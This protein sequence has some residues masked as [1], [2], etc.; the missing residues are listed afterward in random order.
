MSNTQR[1]IASPTRTRQA[2]RLLPVLSELRQE[3]RSLSRHAHRLALAQAGGDDACRNQLAQLFER[4]IED[5]SPRAQVICFASAAEFG[6]PLHRHA[7]R[8]RAAAMCDGSDAVRALY[9][10]ALHRTRSRVGMT[11]QMEDAQGA[12][13][14]PAV[15][16]SD[17]VPPAASARQLCRRCERLRLDARCANGHGALRPLGDMQWRSLAAGVQCQ[18]REHQCDTCHTRWTQHRSSADPFTAWT[19]SR[20]GVAVPAR[21]V[22]M[23]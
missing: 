14:Q 19:I 3:V 17:Q 20:R 6:L 11:A 9:W 13:A 1:A 21:G 4:W 22:L 16:A 15:V 8:C 5:G 10:A 2:A 7:E 12:A 18:T 23:A